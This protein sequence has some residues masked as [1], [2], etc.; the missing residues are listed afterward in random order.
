MPVT[1][2]VSSAGSSNSSAD[3]SKRELSE[4]FSNRESALPVTAGAASAAGSSKSS[5]GSSRLSADF[6]NS[7]EEDCGFSSGSSSSPKMSLNALSTLWGLSSSTGAAVCGFSSGSSSSPKISLNALSTLWGLSSSTSF[8]KTFWAV[9]SAAT[10]S[11][12]NE[13]GRSSFAKGDAG[14][15]G[16]KSSSSP[17]MSL[18]AELTS[19]PETFSSSGNSSGIEGSSFKKSCMAESSE[20]W[21]LSMAASSPLS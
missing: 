1:A 2:G 12:S 11:S 7:D 20:D 6:S 13:V 14:A 21:R 10:G 4:D 18:K 15:S 3:F 17:N 8:P 19:L 5:D 16:S 9:V